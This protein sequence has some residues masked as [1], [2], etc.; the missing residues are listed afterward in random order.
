MEIY[1]KN[2]TPL[3]RPSLCETCSMAFIA[4]GYGETE[5]VVVCQAT[6]PDIWIRFQVRECTEYSDK[7]KPA[8]WQMEK[9]ALVL[10]RVALKRDA[11]F[12]RRDVDEDKENQVELVLDDNKQ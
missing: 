1:V 7:T 12:V 5:V 9:I 4:R 10:D 11:G 6:D 3:D 8:F 2:G